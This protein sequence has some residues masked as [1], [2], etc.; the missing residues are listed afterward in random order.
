[1]QIFELTSGKRNLKEYD[2][3]RSPPAKVNY[4]TGVGPGV[5]PQMTVT[6][7]VNGASP[8]TATTPPAA[9][10]AAPNYGTGVG[11]GVK[12][13]MTVTPTVTNT[14]PAAATGNTVNQA[15]PANPNVAAQ[16]PYV[17]GRAGQG[18]NPTRFA[19]YNP[20][21]SSMANLDQGMRAMTTPRPETEPATDPGMANLSQ[22]MRA[23][24]T[25]MAQPETSVQAPGAYGQPTYNVPLAKVPAANTMMPTNMST[26]GTPVADPS[27]ADA[28]KVALTPNKAEKVDIGGSI[29]KAMRAYNAN[30]AGVGSLNPDNNR[31]PNNVQTDKEGKI[32]IKGQPY[33]ANNPEHVKAYKDFLIA[34][35]ESPA[36]AAPTPA[37]ATA[38]PTAAP[39]ASPKP[40]S[41]KPATTPPAATPKPRAPAAPSS[42]VEQALIKLGFSPQQAAISAKKVPPGM[43]EQDAIKLALSGKLKESLSWSRNFDP[44]RTLYNKMKLQK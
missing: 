38:Q 31:N 16:T 36:V 13:Q 20:S 8:A 9:P 2:P 30:Q 22:G 6:P 44:G 3:S 23:M 12:P 24:T 35:G 25:P 34:A 19:K 5:K 32:T 26:T 4:G 39:A 14:P 1:M 7:T 11:P 28:N 43:S 42:G 15:N 17:Q 10:A 29:V 41:P 27:L 40:A 33:N 18:S 21:T 37:T